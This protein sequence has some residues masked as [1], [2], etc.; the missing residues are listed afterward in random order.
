MAICDEE[1]K[2]LFTRSDVEKLGQKSAAVLDR[3]FTV[4][5]RLSGVAE[6]D[7]EELANSF[8]DGL[9]EDSTLG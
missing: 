2:P 3:L 1:G 4:A 9:S 6:K 5:Q 8:V 7:V